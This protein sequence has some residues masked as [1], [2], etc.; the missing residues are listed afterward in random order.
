MCGNRRGLIL[1]LFC[2]YKK[3]NEE[4]KNIKIINKEGRL[5]NEIK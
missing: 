1:L 3:I 2:F 4:R 5:R